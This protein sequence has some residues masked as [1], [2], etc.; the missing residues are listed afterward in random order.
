MIKGSVTSLSWEYLGYSVECDRRLFQDP[1][2]CRIVDEN[3][4]KVPNDIL[5]QTAD[6]SV[7]YCLMGTKQGNLLNCSIDSACHYDD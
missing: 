4:I 3:G 5:E 7:E 2:N 6:D 1:N